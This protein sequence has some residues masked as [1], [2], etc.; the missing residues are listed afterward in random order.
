VK[1]GDTLE[2]AVKSPLELDTLTLNVAV[3]PIARPVK[4]RVVPA[5]IRRMIAP[6][7]DIEALT[8]YNRFD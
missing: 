1:T 5:I 2:K 4:L 8:S 7:P 6:E 3:E